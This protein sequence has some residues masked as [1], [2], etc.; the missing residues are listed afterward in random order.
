MI[1]ESEPARPSKAVPES[2]RLLLRIPEVAR[3]L[4]VGTS[5]TY[6]LVSEGKIPSMRIGHAVLVPRH[7]LLRWIEEQCQGRQATPLEVG[8][9]RDA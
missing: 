6:Q 1:E 4:S 8:W 7:L 9:R 2:D 3:L 5:V